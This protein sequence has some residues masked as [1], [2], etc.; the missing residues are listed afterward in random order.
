MPFSYLT[1]VPVSVR[2][3]PTVRFWHD[4]HGRESS[5]NRLSEAHSYFYTFLLLATTKAE[6]LPTRQMASWLLK[7]LLPAQ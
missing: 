6:L 4:A 3:H 7:A 5:G 2:A 1:F